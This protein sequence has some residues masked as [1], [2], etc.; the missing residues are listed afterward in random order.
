MLCCVADH[1]RIQMAAFSGIDLNRGRPSSADTLRIARGLLIA[2]NHRDRPAVPQRANGRDQQCCLAG[3]GAGDEV[4]RKDPVLLETGAVG[5]GKCVILGKDIT[6]DADDPL[7][8]EA[9]HV[10]TGRPL[11]KI[12][13]AIFMCVV[14]VVLVMDMGTGMARAW[15]FDDG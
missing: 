3:A 4:Q 11:G 9:R 13:D 1:V 15:I 6:F 2:L 5:V 12:D 7:R 14:M 8:A 10:D